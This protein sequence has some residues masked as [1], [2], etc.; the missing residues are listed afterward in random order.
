[1][2]REPYLQRKR[3]VI[4]MSYREKAEKLFLE[5]YNCAQS[6]LLAFEDVTGLPR[7]T[8]AKLSSSFGGGMGRMREVCGAL[9]GAFMVLG[10]LYGYACPEAGEE[11][12][13]HYARIQELSASFRAMHGTILCRELLER[14]DTAP[15]PSARTPEYYRDRP[16]ARLVGDAAELV[17]RYME[18]YGTGSSPEKT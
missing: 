1:M 14:P 6:V 7:E 17:E 2:K 4:P 3:C 5:G 13:A 11:K 15:V 8:A 16:C 9:T 10:L 18:Q 12:A